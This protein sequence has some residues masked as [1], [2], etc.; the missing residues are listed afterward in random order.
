MD[1]GRRKELERAYHQ[2]TY[3][4]AIP[5]RLRIGEKNLLLDAFLTDLGAT[6]FSYLTAWNPRSTPRSEDENRA[7]QEEL[8][9]LLREAGYEVFVGAGEADDG[10]FPAEPSLL[11]PGLPREEALALARRYEQDAFVSGETGKAPM[12]VWT[13]DERGGRTTSA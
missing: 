13:E 5:L 7:A 10:S 3:A 9:A 6:C 4:A 12:L 1:S 11:V 2:T 8:T